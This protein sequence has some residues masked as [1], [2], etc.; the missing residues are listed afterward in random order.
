ML[1]GAYVVRCSLLLVVVAVT[2]CGASASVTTWLPPEADIGTARTLVFTDSY[3]RDESV[4][5][6]NSMAR[7]QALQGAP[8]RWFLNVQQTRERLETDGEQ[9]WLG[10]DTDLVDD[11]LFVRLDVLEDNAVVSV[12]EHIATAP[13]GANVLVVDETLVAHTLLA[14]TAADSDG[15]VLWE[16]EVEGVHERTGAVAMADIVDAQNLAAEAAVAGALALITPTETVVNVPF[17]ERD[18]AALDLARR[19]VDGDA[20]ARSDLKALDST[21]ARYNFAV[22]V[23]E[24]GDLDTAVE[25][26]RAVANATD[27]AAFYDDTLA[28]AVD[29]RAAH[30]RLG[31][32]SGPR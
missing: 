4:H 13:D 2:G 15:V 11:A 18:P 3:G 31:V 22:V 27:A 5:V 24:G 8:S 25:L 1:R 10:R 26:Y 20:R 16:R 32:S 28:S 30:A 21:A 9:A 12:N 19:A 6:V 14:M 7:A 17:D 23:D 29:R